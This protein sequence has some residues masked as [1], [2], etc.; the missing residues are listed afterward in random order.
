[1]AMALAVRPPGRRRS[2][3]AGWAAAAAAVGVAVAAAAAFA[4]ASRSRSRRRRRCQES[5][6]AGEGGGGNA[7]ADRLVVPA[8]DW[9]AAARLVGVVVWARLR[10]AWAD[11]ETGTW[12]AHAAAGGW[13][14]GWTGGVGGHRLVGR[15]EGGGE[16]D[17]DTAGAVP[18]AR[19][20]PA[21]AAT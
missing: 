13:T 14:G 4:A 20:L 2:P 21:M 12:T 16:L 7:D 3:A 6:R 11:D 17:V 8:A 10:G 15:A 9:A 18:Y 1:M 5:G 19:G